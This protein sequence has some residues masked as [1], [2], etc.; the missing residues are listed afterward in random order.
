MLLF[1][2]P[3]WGGPKSGHSI[4]GLNLQKFE[5]PW[6]RRVEETDLSRETWNAGWIFKDG[7]SFGPTAEGF[8]IFSLH[9]ANTVYRGANY[10]TLLVK[11]GP[12]KRAT[13][14]AHGG[15]WEQGSGGYP[16]W[17]GATWT[18]AK[19][20]PCCF[21]D[22]TTPMTV[23]LETSS[24]W[25]GKRGGWKPTEAINGDISVAELMREL[26]SYSIHG[27]WVHQ[28]MGW[29]LQVLVGLVRLS[30]CLRLVTW[31]QAGCCAPRLDRMPSRPGMRILDLDQKRHPVGCHRA[32]RHGELEGW[33]S[34]RLRQL[35]QRD[36]VHSL[37][38]TVNNCQNCG[39][40]PVTKSCQCE[41][42]V[43]LG[44]VEGATSQPQVGGRSC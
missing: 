8:I 9:M 37:G 34:Q 38:K 19:G 25:T 26:W 2:K 27:R 20:N 16:Q 35:G 31:Q 40:S 12:G 7:G 17:V 3:T 21:P 41:T 23:N 14:S 10:L 15:R 42:R 36:K 1:G 5:S 24:S 22:M 18:T 33:Q 43:S 30:I 6:L 44:W 13:P 32:G 28:Q 29:W 11:G 4:M 39:G